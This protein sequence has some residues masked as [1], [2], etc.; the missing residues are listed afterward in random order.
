MKK[1]FLPTWEPPRL[2]KGNNRW[3]IVLYAINDITKLRERFRFTFNLNRIKDV[4]TRE[5]RG[6]EIVDKLT[7]WLEQGRP[8]SLFEE[9]K[10][11]N[12]ALLESQQDHLGKTNVVEAVDY[13]L[14]LKSKTTRKD[15]MRSYGSTAKFFILYLRKHRWD[16]LEVNAITRRHA[17]GYMDS[18]LVDRDLGA[19]AYNNNLRYMRAIFNELVRKEYIDASP[20][21]EIPYMDKPE[22]QRRN[23]TPREARLVITRIREE[24]QLLFYALLLE[25]CCFMRPSEIMRLMREDIDLE[26]GMVTIPSSKAKTKKTRYVTIPADFLHYFDPVFIDRIPM[27]FY[28]FGEGFKPGRPKPC[29]KNTMGKR[30]RRILLRMQ[31]EGLLVDI[32]G[33]HWY[34]WKDTGITDALEM[35]DMNILAVQDQAGHHTPDMTLKYRHK[36]KVNKRIKDRFKNNLL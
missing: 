25:Y 7:W 23:F 4:P 19:Y 30:H 26:N 3:Y 28:V 32:S 36:K 13:I 27:K 33:L 29:N 1:N 11:P 34:S 22:K 10:V 14:Q 21:T 17:A 12:S 5:K 6:Q 9:G 16:R 35:D 15:T 24:S 31:K 8:I 20:F 2:V 18:C